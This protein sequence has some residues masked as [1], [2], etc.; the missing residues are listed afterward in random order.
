MPTWPVSLPP[1]L[2]SGFSE[3]QP[4]NVIRT[5]MD[6]GPAKLR[7]RTTANVGKISVSYLLSSAELDT[8]I[9]F[10]KTDVSYGALPFTFTHPR[11]AAALS[12]RFAQPFNYSTPD[13]KNYSVTV[14]M[15]VM[16]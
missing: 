14:Q 2:V 4:E 16:P 1:P 12:C 8:L 11:S 13:G 5:S 10:F 9:N 3:Q 15:E 7:R 6:A